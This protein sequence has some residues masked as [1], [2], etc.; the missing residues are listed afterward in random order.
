M[1]KKLILFTSEFPFGTG[2]TFLENEIPYLSRAFEQVVLVPTEQV[3]GEHRAIPENMAIEVPNFRNE[4]LGKVSILKG[5]FH[6]DFLHELFR[7]IFVYGFLPTPKRVKTALVSL[8]RGKQMDH[9][10]EQMGIAKTGTVLYSYWCNDAAI[11]ISLFKRMNPSVRAVTRTHGWD[12]YFEASTIGYLPY[13]DLITTQLDMVCPVSEVGVK[14]IL[15]K[16]KC[17]RTT[18]VELARLG[19]EEQI[20]PTAFPDVFTIVSCSN[21]IPLKRVHLII[22]ALSSIDTIPIRWVHFG[23]GPLWGEL[24]DLANRELPSN[25]SWKFMGRIPNK[26]VLQWYCENP[27]S[28]FINVSETEG[29]PVS[30][31]E[32]MS[33]GIPVIATNVGGTGEIVRDEVYLLNKELIP[34]EL[35]KSLKRMIGTSETEAGLYREKIRISWLEK[36]AASPNYSAFCSLLSSE[37]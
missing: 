5:I 18:N 11:G 19:V 7:I 35:T 3:N 37:R 2:E 21:L 30:I 32:A 9:W 33:F 34:F 6:P 24:N 28:V 1:P 36:S 27:V 22:E 26:E 8:L 23:D 31:M 10:L 15:E 17:K 29:V 25:I 20:P 16:W 12:L 13:R 14:Y 4:K